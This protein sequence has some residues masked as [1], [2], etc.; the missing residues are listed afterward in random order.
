[1]LTTLLAADGARA[2]GNATARL[3]PLVF[4]LI[5]IG[6]G[7]WRHSRRQPGAPRGRGPNWLIGIGGTLLVVGIAGAVGAGSAG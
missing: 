3:L 7:V 2:A 5:L 1:M 4:G 6:I